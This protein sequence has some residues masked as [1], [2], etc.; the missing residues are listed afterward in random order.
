MTDK[1]N[2]QIKLLSA[3]YAGVRP[4]TA[5]SRGFRVGRMRAHRLCSLPP[6]PPSRPSAKLPASIR[7]HRSPFLSSAL[8]AGESVFINVRG[9]QV[10]CEFFGVML[11]MTDNFTQKAFP[12]CFSCSSKKRIP[13]V[14]KLHLEHITHKEFLFP[15]WDEI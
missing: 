2:S 12:V 13:P 10:Q 8:G 14:Y 11:L 5:Q 6:L 7:S 15:K 4:F 1:N 3:P 9:G